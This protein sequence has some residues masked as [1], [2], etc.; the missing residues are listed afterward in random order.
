M[1][2]TPRLP[3]ETLQTLAKV[4]RD[5]YGLLSS[6]YI[7]IPEIKVFE[8]GWEPAMELLKHPQEGSDQIF[9]EVQKGLNLVKPYGPEKAR[10]DETLRNLSRDWTRLF[11]GIDR[12]GILPPYESL[13]RKERLQRKPAQEI[14]RLFSGMGIQVPEEWHQPSDYIGV[15]L[16][17]MRL[18]CEKEFRLRNDGDRDALQEAVGAES[19]FLEDHLALWVPAFCT[20]M[21]EEAREAY[22]LGIAHLTS[23]LVGFDRLWVPRLFN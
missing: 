4:R 20:R 13:Y 23:G 7:H 22:Y 18:L 11:R 10:T 6:A 1:A 2:E 8:L 15:E 16:D 9:K 12:N 5:L 19:S 17:F 21:L 3:L 14:N